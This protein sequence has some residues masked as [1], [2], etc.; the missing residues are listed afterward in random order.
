[1][2][3]DKSAAENVRA[4]L[5]SAWAVADRCIIAAH[6]ECRPARIDFSSTSAR[7]R[8]TKPPRAG[9]SVAGYSVKVR[10][11]D[12]GTQTAPRPLRNSA[13]KDAR[14]DQGACPESMQKEQIDQ[15]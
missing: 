7:F 5:A 14:V 10:L 1:M 11:L 9:K 6:N 13:D 15:S 3:E 8:R 2:I 12:M 4:R